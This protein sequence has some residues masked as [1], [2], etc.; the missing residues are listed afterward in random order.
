MDKQIKA[1]IKEKKH[2]ITLQDES[3]NQMTPYKYFLFLKNLAEQNH[4]LALAFSMHLYTAWG[5]NFILDD[6]KRNKFLNVGVRKENKL[7][8]SL[9]EP[10]L[11]FTRVDQINPEQFLI[12]SYE[13]EN[14]FIV[15]GTKKFVS[16]SPFVSYFPVYC[17]NT[18][19]FGKKEILVLLIEKEF[20]GVKV[21]NDW[22]SI[23]MVE[24]ATHS[25]DF[26]NVFVPFDNLVCER[27]KSLINTKLFNYL[28]RL[29]ICSV[30][31]GMAK[32]TLNI[33]LESIKKK[34]VPHY[35][36][37]MTSLPGIQFKIADLFTKLEVMNSQIK[38]YCEKL[39]EY[40]KDIESFDGYIQ[41]KD[42]E[43]SSLITKLFVVENVEKV[44]NK[45]MKIQGMSSIL[46]NNEI[47]KIYLDIKA[48]QFHPPQEDISKEL[49]AKSKLGI[50]NVRQ[51]WF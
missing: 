19:K 29:S 30:Y 1:L 34:K 21:N 51:R 18:N 31:F 8:A 15:N 50:L 25:V 24:T 23:S 43:T 37:N 12:K 48:S 35:N 5:L 49:I 11:Y 44:V 32:K 45:S 33:T 42:I 22:N 16:L 10:N 28:F 46:K 2:I 4:A 26:E 47:S 20:S 41:T 13:V 27:T 3:G 38:N 7:F 40:L 17:F 9:N 39:E 14:G 36:V 6:S